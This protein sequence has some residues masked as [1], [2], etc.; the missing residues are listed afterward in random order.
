MNRYSPDFISIPFG[1]ASHGYLSAPAADL[2]L[3]KAALPRPATERE[4]G[5]YAAIEYGIAN[6]AEWD[7]RRRRD[8]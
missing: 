5:I 3:I 1:V 6:P 7:A 8:R 2:P 4:K